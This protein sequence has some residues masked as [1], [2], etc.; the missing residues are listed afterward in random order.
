MVDERFINRIMA[1]AAWR[2][3]RVYPDD[4]IS[5]T[6]ASHPCLRWAYLGRRR[7]PKPTG[8]EALLH[9]GNAIHE[10]IQIELTREGYETEVR[11][12]LNLD[13]IRIVGRADA[14]RY[15]VTPLAEEV[16]VDVLEFKTVEELPKKPHEHHVMQ[17][18]AYLNILESDVGHIIY[19]DRRVGRIKVFKVRRNPKALNKIKERAKQLHEYL[20]KDE[21]PPPKQGPWCNYCPYKLYCRKY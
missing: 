4:V 18:Q 16:A 1:R 11:L 13:G 3:R 20:M 14:V 7:Q 17:L 21:L 6:E 10:M 9:L 19:I 15:E 8:Y 2:M 5:V 12:A